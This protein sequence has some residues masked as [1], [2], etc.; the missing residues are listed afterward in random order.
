MEDFLTSH[1]Q[2]LRDNGKVGN[3]Y[4]YL[5]LRTTLHNFHGKKLNLL[6]NAVD[7][8]SSLSEHQFCQILGR[9]R[10]YQYLPMRLQ[11]NI[12][13]LL[14]TDTQINNVAKSYISDED[15]G[16]YGT[17]INMWNFYNLLTGANKSSYIDM[18][19]DRSLNAS[20]IAMGINGALHGEERYKW[21]ID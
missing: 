21:F 18:F 14:I 11:R 8:A 7:V 20:E 2:Q 15:F 10:L 4:A 1:I 12:P 16:S 19:L 17:D 6:F 5:N 3:S 13:R 9:M